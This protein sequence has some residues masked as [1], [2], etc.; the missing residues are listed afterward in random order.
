[1]EAVPKAQRRT[2]Q[3]VGSPRRPARQESHRGPLRRVRPASPSPGPAVVAGA[4]P[5]RRCCRRAGHAAAHLRL[6]PTWSAG[7]RGRAAA[8]RPVRDQHGRH[9]RAGADRPGRL[10][11]ARAAGRR[12]GGADRPPR[13]GGHPGRRH[14]EHRRRPVRHRRRSQHLRPRPG[15]GARGLRPGDLRHRAAGPGAVGRRARPDGRA[16]LLRAAVGGRRQRGAERPG[17]DPHR[18]H[19]SAGRP[20][21]RLRVLPGPG[22]VAD[23]GGLDP[24][25]VPAGPGSD[26]PDRRELRGAV[27][28]LAHRPRGGDRLLPAP[29]LAL[30][31]GDRARIRQPHGDRHVDARR[32]GT[33]SWRAG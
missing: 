17:R 6:L 20:G 7:V 5:G 11:R 15:T 18:G 31:G 4:V 3:V 22:A 29:G 24:D 1:M 32:P 23:R 33:R 30:A 8:D 28:R 16:D 12:G 9:P 21:L 25:H 2:A 14:G 26:L 10:D 19:G 13:G 27:P